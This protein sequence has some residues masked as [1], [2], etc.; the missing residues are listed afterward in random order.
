MGL[1]NMNLSALLWHF[2][3]YV[4][5]TCYHFA[6]RT[7]ILP[8]FQYI[9]DLHYKCRQKKYSTEF[10]CEV[11]LIYRLKYV[12]FKCAW[13]PFSETECSFQ[14]R[15]IYQETYDFWYL[16]NFITLRLYLEISWK[17]WSWTDGKLLSSANR[18]IGCL[19]AY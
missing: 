3:Q 11:T 13:A 19:R 16:K 9:S 6:W 2:Q 14:L 7:Q 18:W 8:I 17:Y 5:S 4:S 12:I 1:Q 10:H 15:S